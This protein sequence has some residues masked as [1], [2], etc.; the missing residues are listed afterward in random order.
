MD[1][2]CVDQRDKEARV[3][4]TQYIPR[5]FRHAQRTV[6]VKDEAAIQSCCV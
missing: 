6:F 4:V 5:I 3:A 2:L 1:V